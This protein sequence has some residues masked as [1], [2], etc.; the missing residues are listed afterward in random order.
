MEGDIPCAP[1]GISGQAK[2]FR[3]QDLRYV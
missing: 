1:A 3:T 2:V